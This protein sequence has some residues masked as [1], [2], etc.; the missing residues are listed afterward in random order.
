MISIKDIA[1]KCNVSIATVSKA[2][3]NAP[4][5]SKSTKSKILKVAEELGYTANYSARALRTNRTHNIGVLYADSQKIFTHD[6][7]S[8]V[9]ESFKVEAEKNGYDIT[10]INEHLLNNNTTYRKYCEFRSFDGVVIITAKFDDKEILEL[11]QS[12]IPVV[13]I[14]HVYNNCSSV[15]SDNTNGMSELLE[16]AIKL[17]HKK[18]AYIHGE[19]T[20][21][22]K[23]RLTGFYATMAKYK[24]SIPD[25][26]L[27]EGEYRNPELAKKKTEELLSLK[28]PP[29]CI[30]Y[31][32]D[33]SMLLAVQ[34]IKESGLN[35]SYL[36]YDGIDISKIMNIT[37][38]EQDRQSLGK[39]AARK[40]IDR[41]ENPNSL[42][43]HAVINGKV[44]IGD[45]VKMIKD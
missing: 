8:N 40:L 31:P 15:I 24:L 10:F 37:T 14:D 5:I 6:F 26:Y 13:T 23:D 38:Y 45:S 27:V 1:R 39:F 12:D 22:T 9:L 11:V 28:N 7:F 42:I 3:N 29:T 30:C 44:R 19:N 2:L 36:G 34:T 25:E 35:V 17:G 33:Y 16:Y 32:D 21:V 43:E 41:I 18:I 20:W 4:D